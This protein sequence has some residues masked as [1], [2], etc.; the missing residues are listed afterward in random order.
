MLN[1][2]IL[3][4]LTMILL[5][6]CGFDVPDLTDASRLQFVALIIGV[7]V[8]GKIASTNIIWQSNQKN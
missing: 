7:F 8:L 4:M 2:G 3:L 6:W 5:M 1:G